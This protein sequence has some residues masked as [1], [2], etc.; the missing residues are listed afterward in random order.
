LILLEKDWQIIQVRFKRKSDESQ[1][2]STP[3]IPSPSSPHGSDEQPIVPWA[4][5]QHGVELEALPPWA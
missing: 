4:D 5:P 2:R 3:S 1:N